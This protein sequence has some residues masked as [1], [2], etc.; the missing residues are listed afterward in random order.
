MLFDRARLAL[1]DVRDNVALAQR[2]VQGL[3]FKDFLND[4]KTFYAVTRALEIVSEAAR[5]LP[6]DLRERHPELPW[7]AILGIG[8]VYGHNYDNVAEEIVW[9]T[10]Q[11]GLEPLLAVIN[12]EI[13][14]WILHPRGSEATAIVSFRGGHSLES[15][16]F[17]PA[18]RPS[19][20]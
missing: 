17:T 8:N 12:K 4:Q 10:V 9:H 20:S 13:R 5:R 18:V 3:S 19:S 1:Y 6:A 15:T 14:L 11:K 2:F 7:R 16:R